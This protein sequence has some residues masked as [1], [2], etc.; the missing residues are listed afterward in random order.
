MSLPS[1]ARGLIA[2]SI[3]ACLPACL[4]VLGTILAPGAAPARA[5]L[6]DPEVQTDEMSRVGPF[7]LSSRLGL[8]DL[9]YDDNLFLNGRDRVGDYTIT[10]SGGTRAVLRGDRGHALL[11]EGGLDRV[12]Y[13]GRG[14]LDHTNGSG[15]AKFAL[16]FTRA[17]VN[18]EAQRTSRR[19]RPNS[20]IDARLR[21]TDAR[22]ALSATIE[23]T[24]RTSLQF[25]LQHDVIRFDTENAGDFSSVP[26]RLNRAEQV[27]SVTARLQALP[28]SVVLV[29]V[30]RS[31]ARFDDTAGRRDTSTIRTLAG[32]EFDPT[33]A[34]SGA[35]KVGRIHLDARE[36]PG[37]DYSGDVAEVDLAYRV[38]TWGRVRAWYSRDTVFSS[39]ENQLYFLGRDGALSYTHSLSPRVAVE[40]EGGFAR[41]RYPD[42][43]TL[44][45]AATGGTQT[46]RRLD[47]RKSTAFGVRYRT[48]RGVLT[49]VRVIRWARDSNFDAFDADRLAVMG[50]AEYAF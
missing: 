38:R 21:Q 26:R 27:G 1:S 15:R 39:F 47:R 23:R 49:G 50:V 41:S 46:A 3:S 8:K 42:E 32:M 24:G 29:E 45:D 35:F 11:M 17:L 19:E 10:L 9:G 4:I 6:A 20:E 36:R 28:K 18:G 30:R 37:A 12:T 22:Q 31:E 48:A 14:D 25:R 16:I 43:T 13:A 7:Y 33:A 34:V 2:S 44:V 5:E 40:L